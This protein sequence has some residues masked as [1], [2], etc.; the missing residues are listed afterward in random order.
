MNGFVWKRRFCLKASSLKD[1]SSKKILNN[2]KNASVLTKK[3]KPIDFT[4]QE[5]EAAAQEDKDS[6]YTEYFDSR[7]LL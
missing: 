7:D 4:I 6:D 2:N 5:L 3:R 1:K